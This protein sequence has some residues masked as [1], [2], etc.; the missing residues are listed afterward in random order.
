MQTLE[1]LLILKDLFF[2]AMHTS[3][4]TFSSCAHRTVVVKETSGHLLSFKGGDI[5]AQRAGAP[6]SCGRQ[7]SEQGVSILSLTLYAMFPSGERC[8]HLGELPHFLLSLLSFYGMKKLFP[9][10]Q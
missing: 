4:V 5:E 9:K 7:V 10:K 8:D 3:V 2:T 1:H 6:C